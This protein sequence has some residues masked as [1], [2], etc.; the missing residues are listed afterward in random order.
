MLTAFNNLEPRAQYEFLSAC[1]HPHTCKFAADDP[2]DVPEAISHFL[3]SLLGNF[4]T[5][6]IPELKKSIPMIQLKTLMI[7]KKYA[8]EYD[9]EMSNLFVIIYLLEEEEKDVRLYLYKNSDALKE[10]ELEEILN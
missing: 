5:V 3:P 7:L 2:L 4:T 10:I 9:C 1:A 6:Y 8:K